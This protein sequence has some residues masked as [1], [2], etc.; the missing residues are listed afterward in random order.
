VEDFVGFRD[1][2]FCVGIH[3]SSNSRWRAR[4]SAVDS[5]GDALLGSG[6]R[7]LRLDDGAGRALFERAPM[8]VSIFTRDRDLRL[9]LR[10]VV[11]GRARVPSGVAAVMLATI[12]VFMALREIIF[13][14][15]QKLTVRLAL[16]LLVGI[17]GVAVLMSHAL[18]LSGAP[19]DKMGATALMFACM[20]WSVASALARKVPLPLRK[21]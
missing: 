20:S 8:D 19:T 2:L 7:S 9:R 10:P 3:I 18:N 4:S 12:P 11:L 14:R 17:G 6:R 16:A 13:L 21:S 1:Y 15:T 5:G